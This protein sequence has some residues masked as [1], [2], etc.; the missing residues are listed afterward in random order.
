MPAAPP[1]QQSGAS[2]T[3]LFGASVSPLAK[4]SPQLGWPSGARFALTGAVS[5][6]G[7]P[8]P[9]ARPRT[10]PDKNAHRIRC[11]A[12]TRVFP[13]NRC[14]CAA[15]GISP[16]TKKFFCKN[17]FQTKATPLSDRTIFGQVFGRG[18]MINSQN[19]K[20]PLPGVKRA[21]TNYW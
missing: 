3:G 13:K 17:V 1:P 21:V 18:G 4:G 14:E 16:D 20:S 10:V 6:S 11:P 8:V 12:F 2:V 15:S 5:E 7:R 9:R 19:A